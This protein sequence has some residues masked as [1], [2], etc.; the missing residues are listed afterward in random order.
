MDIADAIK[1]LAW[2]AKLDNH[3]SPEVA[4]YAR[5]QINALRSTVPQDDEAASC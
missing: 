3:D 1:L 2:Y 4:L 5:A